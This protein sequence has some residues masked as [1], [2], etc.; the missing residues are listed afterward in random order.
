MNFSIFHGQRPLP[1][2]FNVTIPEEDINHSAEFQRKRR[3]QC[4][5]VSACE[6]ACECV[7]VS[8]SASVCVLECVSWTAKHL[9][10]RA[11]C[12]RMSERVD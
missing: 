2:F 11:L 8:N 7:S 12:A 1:V 10:L 9:C 4:E 3:A 5:Q 6:R